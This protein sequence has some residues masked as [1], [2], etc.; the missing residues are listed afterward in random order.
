MEDGNKRREFLR[1]A[2]IL[3]A[4]VAPPPPHH[5]GSGGIRFRH[6]SEPDANYGQ[7]GCQRKALC[8]AGPQSPIGGQVG[9]RKT[10]CESCN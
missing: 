3:R 9:A 4:V 10:R 5:P 6:S 8:Q 1:R 7:M 2:D